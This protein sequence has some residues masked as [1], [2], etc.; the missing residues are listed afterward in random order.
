MS[1]WLLPKSSL[2]KISKS[3]AKLIEINE[4][5][6]LCDIWRIRN[7]QKNVTHFIRIRFLVSFNKR[8][9][10]F[11]VSKTLQVFVKK[12]DVFASLLTDHLPLLFSIEKGDDSVREEDYR[13]LGL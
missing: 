6:N 2:A 12:T 13:G 9:D 5:L 11:F 3:L 1:W 7:H 10:Y 4:S 8:L